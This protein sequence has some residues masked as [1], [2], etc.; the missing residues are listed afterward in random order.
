MHIR[1]L[2]DWT[3]KLHDNLYNGN[4]KMDVWIDGPYGNPSGIF[5]SFIIFTFD[6]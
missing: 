1:V 6:I 5:F 3:K 4:E 2:G